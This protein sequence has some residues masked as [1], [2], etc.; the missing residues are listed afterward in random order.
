[1]LIEPVSF[2]VPG[3]AIGKARAR[4]VVSGV[5]RCANGKMRPRI[6]HYTP[7]KTVSWETEIAMRARAAMRGRKPFDGPVRV[8]YV[9]TFATPASWPRWKRELADAGRIYHTTKPDRDNIDKALC[10]ALNGIAWTDDCYAVAGGQRKVYGPVPQ[11]AVCITPL[12]G[13]PAQIKK[14][15][16]A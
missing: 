9:A 3:D 15:P 7:A 13:F 10:D 14:N 12:V 11:L 1:M 8:D 4:A 5:V 16:F 2:V 6:R